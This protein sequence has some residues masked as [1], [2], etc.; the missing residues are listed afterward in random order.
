MFLKKKRYRGADIG[1]NGRIPAGLKSLLLAKNT[2]DS[3]HLRA[4][5]S[6]GWSFFFPYT[7]TTIF[8]AWNGLLFL[9]KWIIERCSSFCSTQYC[10]RISS[11]LTIY[12]SELGCKLCWI[13]KHEKLASRKFWAAVDA[14]NVGVYLKAKILFKGAICKNKLLLSLHAKQRME[15]AFRP[16]MRGNPMT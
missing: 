11:N 14:I 10:S 5:I 13:L 2:V 4:L 12:V 8:S 9:C 7:L 1:E 6:R 16:W 15:E 3:C